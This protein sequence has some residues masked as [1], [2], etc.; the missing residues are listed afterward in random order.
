MWW[1][2]SPIIKWPVNTPKDDSLWVHARQSSSVWSRRNCPDEW[3]VPWIELDT[4]T[5]NR[6]ELDTG[7]VIRI[8]LGTGTVNRIELDTGTVNRIELGTGTVPE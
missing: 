4:G 8:E 3:Q 2:N 1:T 5:V 6:I 7:T